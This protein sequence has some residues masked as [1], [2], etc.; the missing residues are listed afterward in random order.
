M[1]INMQQMTVITCVTLLSLTSA[2]ATRSVDKHS[3]NLAASCA[4]CHGTNGHS[5]GGAPKLAGLDK[6]YFITQMQNMKS[7]A[8]ATTVMNKHAKGYS[9]EEFAKLADFFSAQK[10]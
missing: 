3:R 1:K 2:C 6:T 4:A 5:V 7:G 9:E 8:R 10:P